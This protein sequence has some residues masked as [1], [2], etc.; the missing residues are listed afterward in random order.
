[1]HLQGLQ[2]FQP[3][4]GG[5]EQQEGGGGGGL[6]GVLQH[7][8]PPLPPLQQFEE[9]RGAHIHQILQGEHE[10]PVQQ[11]LQ[12][13]VVVVVVEVVVVVVDVVEVVGVVIS[14]GGP[15]GGTSGVVPG[16]SQHPHPLHGSHWHG[17][18]QT[19]LHL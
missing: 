12:G 14:T 8:E 1:M 19:I 15:P 17:T 7:P 16:V 9:Q 11:G 13:C 10:H 4:Q 5:H 2:T 18:H 6:G 3:T